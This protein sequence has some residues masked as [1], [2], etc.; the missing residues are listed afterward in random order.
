MD[1]TDPTRQSLA[2]IT[3]FRPHDEIVRQI[4]LWPSLIEM[5]RIFQSDMKNAPRK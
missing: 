4:N 2:S 1:S 5:L 3:K